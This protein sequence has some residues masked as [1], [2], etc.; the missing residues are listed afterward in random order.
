MANET[1]T[2]R[3]IDA[4]EMSIKVEVLRGA[5]PTRHC[6]V[7][8]YRGQELFAE[9]SCSSE[10]VGPAQFLLDWTMTL[11]GL[12]AD[13]TALTSSLLR[14]RSASTGP[15]P[16]GFALSEALSTDYIEGKDTERLKTSRHRS[17]RPLAAHVFVCSWCLG[18]AD[19]AGQVGCGYKAGQVR[20]HEAYRDGAS[21][22]TSSAKRGPLMEPRIRVVIEG[23]D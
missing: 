13:D 14:T 7:G 22:K 4:L 23:G 10:P 17:S 18:N 20:M 16:N 12:F 1:G 2:R 3:V 8:R 6:V 15:R 9:A 5:K 21:D 19:T 11:G